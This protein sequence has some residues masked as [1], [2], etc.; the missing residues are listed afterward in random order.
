MKHSQA[1]NTGH[2]ARVRDILKGLGFDSFMEHSQVC[3]TRHAVR[4]T[5][6][7]PCNERAKM[8]SHTDK[9]TSVSKRSLDEADQYKAECNKS[10]NSQNIVHV[11]TSVQISMHVRERA[12][13]SI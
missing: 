9:R 1:C 6:K 7:I 8:D 2:A 11:C 10:V 4:V 12:P 5:V 3:N 13:I